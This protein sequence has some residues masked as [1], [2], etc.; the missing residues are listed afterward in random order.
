MY[1]AYDHGIYGALEKR[2]DHLATSSGKPRQVLWRIYSKRALL[3]AGAIERSIAFGNNDRPGIML[4]GAVRTYVNRFGVTPGKR[5]AAFTNNEDGL[6]TASDLRAKGI[7]VTEVDARQGNTIVDTKGR[8][9]VRSVQLSNGQSIEVDCVAVSGGWSPTVA[10]T[11]HHRG[12]PVW[13]DDICGFVPAGELPPGMTVA[14][15]ANGT[16]TLAACLKDGHEKGAALA[17]DLGAAGRSGDCAA[18][19]DESF[20]I[21]PFWHVGSSKHRA[22]VDLQ[23]D[24][25]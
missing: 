24:V 25:T 7:D 19:T 10:L 16:M 20:E 21:K 12:R 8:K 18:A 13:K 23:N 14:G 22:W 1:G 4:A 3:A 15:A 9:G 17:R 2:T 6:R 5:V 11:C